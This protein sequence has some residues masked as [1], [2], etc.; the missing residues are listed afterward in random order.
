M[1][2]PRL[3]KLNE[4]LKRELS[5][6]I[7]TKVRDPRVGH[8]TLTAVETAGDL[9]SARI[10]VRVLGDTDELSDTLAGLE[11]AAPFLRRELGGMLRIRKVPEL[12]FQEDRSMERAQRIEEILSEVIPDQGDETADPAGGDETA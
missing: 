10:Y 3:A 5:M 2:A 7:R 11:A 6:L 12:R 1:P 9:G 4:Q 8:V